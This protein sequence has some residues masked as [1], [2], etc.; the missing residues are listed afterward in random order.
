M[1]KYKTDEIKLP[2]FVTIAQA[3]KMGVASAYTL[4]QML[5]RGELPGYYAGTRYYINLDKL[6]EKIGG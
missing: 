5:K 1:Y 4:R 2:R 3:Q 6:L